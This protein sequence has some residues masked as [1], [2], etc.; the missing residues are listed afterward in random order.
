MANTQEERAE[1][2]KSLLAEREE[3]YSVADYTEDT[4]GMSPLQV[5]EAIAKHVLKR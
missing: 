5:A 2:I 3:Y 1:K 4:T